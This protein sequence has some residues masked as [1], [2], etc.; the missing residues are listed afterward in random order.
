M[1][2]VKII[3]K[4]VKDQALASAFQGLLGVN[5][6]NLEI[7]LPKVTKI[8]NKLNKIKECVTRLVSKTFSEEA[9]RQDV[10]DWYK[11]HTIDL[12][13]HLNDV[14]TKFADECKKQEI[15]DDKQ[16]MMAGYIC[17][18]LAKQYS[19]E[20]LTKMSDEYSEFKQSPIISATIVMCRNF[21]HY[22]QDLADKSKLDAKFIENMNG[23]EFRPLVMTRF[24]F[25]SPF[26]NLNTSQAVKQYLLE[27]LHMM[28]T[29][30]YEI[31]KIV[32]SPDIDVE[33]FAQV[34]ID[35]IG[36][37]KKH[38][39]R[40]NEAFDKIEESIGLLRGNFGSYYKDF[41]ITKNPT[42]I[43]ESFV[44]DVAQNTKGNLKL[45]RQFKI[46]VMHY[47]KLSQTKGNVAPEVN[48]LFEKL[49]ENFKTMDN[50]MVDT[51]MATKD[52]VEKDLNDD[53][54]SNT[55]N[56]TPSAENN[57]EKPKKMKKKKKK[58]KS[59]TTSTEQDTHDAEAYDEQDVETPDQSTE[60]S[61]T[62]ENTPQ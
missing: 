8:K 35:N 38:I 23:H 4:S 5:G 51:G 13:E 33:K 61:N 1:A 57:A 45:A 11:Q 14:Y 29:T 17:E 39:P 55:T 31:Y 28:Y 24:N 50:M 62:V 47:K 12:G 22:K 30:S 40:C 16:D 52:E 49:E 27:V 60:T 6:A 7:V 41:V 25:K 54:A 19:Q 21:I 59:Q 46:I 42:T 56:N 10:E 26:I 32:T 34:V 37:L 9:A 48:M 18:E 58:S 20:H 36:N 15:S 44:T 3:Q 2:S 53:T 43:I